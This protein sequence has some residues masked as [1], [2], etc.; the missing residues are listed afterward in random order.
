VAAS[1]NRLKAVEMIKVDIKPLSV[2]EAWKGRRMKSVKYMA[3]RKRVLYTLKPIKLPAGPY[4]LELTYGFSSR[5][6][7]I[8]NPTKM[9]ID[10]LSEKYGF[11]DNE[12][13]ELFIKK[14]IVKKEQEYFEFSI[15]TLNQQP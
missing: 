6:A 9:V 5:G 3:F 7:D 8:D 14:Q 1:S 2:N 11:N 15:T 10:I 13:Y 4:R 12:I